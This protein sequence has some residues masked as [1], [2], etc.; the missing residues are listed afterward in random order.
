M[1]GLTGIVLLILSFFAVPQFFIFCFVLVRFRKTERTWEDSKNALNTWGFLSIIALC[2][3]TI[4][5]I[6]L[7]RLIDLL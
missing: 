2:L 5:M 1:W 7:T 3:G 4:G 6:A